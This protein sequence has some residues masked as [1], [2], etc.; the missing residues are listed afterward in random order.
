M[1]NSKLIGVPSAYLNLI[2]QLA[3]A[4]GV[5][6]DRLLQGLSIDPAHLARSDSRVDQATTAALLLRALSLSGD[7]GFGFAIGLN[8]QMTSHGFVGLGLA[9]FNTVRDVL[10]F[11]RRFVSL[12][13]PFLHMAIRADGDHTFVEVTEAVELG[14]L[15]QCVFEFFLSGLWRMAQQI[16]SEVRA[17]DRRI[18]LCF[19]FAPPAY[20]QD[21]CALL[22][23]C[24]FH[25]PINALR[26]PSELLN[27]ELSTAD[28]STA[29]LVTQQCE[30]ELS[31]IGAAA[32]PFVNR[33]RAILDEVDSDYP[34]LDEL[35]AQLH[36]SARSLKR[37]LQTANSTF[38]QELDAAR[39]R[40]AK[41]LLCNGQL[42]IGEIALRL[43]YR[44]PANFT[45]AFRKWTGE[46]PLAY[47]KKNH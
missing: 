27:Q 16:A 33:V 43:G 24:E 44:E 5:T 18:A 20:F 32:V 9:T 15:R 8:S 4:R 47:R 37:R 22:P 2:V 26:L 40:R 10:E 7:P 13:T 39:L 29:E 46:T 14:P 6:A 28:R 19:D 11:G 23:S 45:R 21:Y 12:R 3:E 31:E 41:R 1:T 38:Q 36:L 35:A 30:R 34:K 42:S 17:D 25:S